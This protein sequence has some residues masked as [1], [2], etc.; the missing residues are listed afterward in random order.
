[1]THF[2]QALLI[3]TAKSIFIWF[4]QLDA[5][6]TSDLPSSLPLSLSPPAGRADGHQM[7]LLLL[8]RRRRVRPGDLGAGPGRPGAAQLHALRSGQPA[9]RVAPQGQAR[10]QGAVDLLVGRGAQPVRRHP[11]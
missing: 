6:S 10:R 8:P 2:K 9:V 3:I 4:A 7:A 1:M 5:T 11:S